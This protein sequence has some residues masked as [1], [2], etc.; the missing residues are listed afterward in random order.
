VILLALE[1]SADSCSV[2]LWDA[3]APAPEAEIAF[4]RS[5]RARGQ[6]DHLVEMVDTVLGRAGL[7]YQA[8]RAIA[9]NCGPGSFTGVRSAVA[10]ARGFALAASLPVVAVSG[11]EALAGSVDAPGGAPILAAIDAGRGEVYAQTFAPGLQPLTEPRPLAPAWA[12]GAVAD[13]ACVLVGSGAP[14]VAAALPEH[15]RVTMA[16]VELDARAIA[17]RAVRRL[18]SGELPQPGFALR[19]LYLREPDARPQ[20][21]LFPAPAAAG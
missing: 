1:N 11:L 4:D 2:A 15:A 5:D 18:A 9:V 21:P 12:V 13:R 19:P 3:A 20:A 8:L 6:A 7:D 17:R 16:A 14:L 10:A